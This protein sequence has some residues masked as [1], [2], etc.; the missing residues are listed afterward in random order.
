M[1]RKAK[2]QLPTLE[3]TRAAVLCCLRDALG[4]DGWEAVQ[5][6]WLDGWVEASEMTVSERVS[7]LL[8]CGFDPRDLADFYK[9]S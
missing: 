8:E 7:E 3:E 5:P 1:A 4:G 6:H 2:K 9:R